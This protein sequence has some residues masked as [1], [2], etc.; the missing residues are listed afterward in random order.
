MS[1][2]IGLSELVFV[3]MCAVSFQVTAAC[4]SS[5]IAFPVPFLGNND[6]V[7]QLANGDLWQVKFEYNYL[8]AYYP[9]VEICPQSNTLV[10]NDKNLNVQ[11]LAS[12]SDLLVESFV[13][14][15]WQ[16]WKGDTIV[17]LINGQQW[18]QSGFE[19]SVNIEA[20]AK[21]LVY[22]SFGT[23]KMVVE[24]EKPVTV[25]PHNFTPNFGVGSGVLPAALNGLSASDGLNNLFILLE[26]EPSDGATSYDMYYSET[27]DGERTLLGSTTATRQEIY[28]TTP[29]TTLYFF[30]FPVN[31]AGVNTGMVD[32]GF[33]ARPA[34]LPP[35]VSI[36]GGDRVVE[37][38]DG[39]NGE[40]VNVSAVATSVVGVVVDNVQWILQ[41]EVVASESISTLFLP[42]GESILTFKATN[43][44]GISSTAIVKVTVVPPVAQNIAP[45]VSFNPTQLTFSDSDELLGEAI[46][47]S[48]SATDED[49]SIANTSWVID[50]VTVAT[51]TN[52]V[53]SLKDGETSVTFRASDNLGLSS[54]VT[55]IFTVVAPQHVYE[56]TEE[57]PAPFNGAPSPSAFN[58]ELN[59]L[60][61]LS[62]QDGYL[63]SCVKI[64]SNGEVASVNGVSEYDMVFSLT[65]DGTLL[66]VKLREFNLTNSAA[67][68]GERPSC[69][70]A[71]ELTRS[72]YEDTILIGDSVFTILLE[73]I[74]PQN[75]EFRLANFSEVQKN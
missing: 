31:S 71:F 39:K 61:F 58:L 33:V 45:S 59:N 54:E 38:S 75:L 73:L 20:L 14:G 29:G 40:F 49:G 15:I 17:T 34:D 11:K 37:D 63:Y 25:V 53:L 19:F 12:K 70:G 43:T 41:D 57:W 28:N 52:A 44:A 32:S 47:L 51:G 5:S 16:G 60:S 62:P 66:I 1:K 36:I 10:I 6:E 64:V 69:S 68:D 65:A 27:Q 2:K 72:T 23:Y 50:G 30:V 22:E 18:K 26:W 35:L 4:S 21:A 74:N 55:V 48:G 46:N 42:N 3:L 24:G 67:Q 56:P 9:S 7:F 13:S 8:Y